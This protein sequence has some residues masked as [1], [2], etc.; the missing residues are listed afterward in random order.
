MDKLQVE[1]VPAGA[2]DAKAGFQIDG[3]TV[4]WW[5]TKPQAVAAA[6]QIGWPVKSVTKVHTRFQIGYALLQ[7]FGGLVTKAGFVALLN[8]EI[9]AKA[10]G[11]VGRILRAD[12]DR[13]KRDDRGTWWRVITTEGGHLVLES[14]TDRSLNRG[15][16]WAFAC[17][18]VDK[19]LCLDDI[20]H[21]VDKYRDSLYRTE[22]K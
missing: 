2:R 22:A 9:H 5:A 16:A 17:V 6:K 14:T 11:E 20:D 12:I 19:P 18:V 8:P 3:S 7:T 1:T 4:Q 15:L 21:E 10:E 13:Y